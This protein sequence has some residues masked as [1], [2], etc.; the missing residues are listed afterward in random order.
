MHDRGRASNDSER[1]R[2]EWKI[3]RS[4]G[5]IARRKG[6]RQEEC[7]EGD[8]PSDGEEATANASPEPDQT[9]PSCAVEGDPLTRERRAEEHAGEGEQPASG[10]RTARSSLHPRHERAAGA[11]KE[12]EKV[13]VVHADPALYEGGAV[14]KREGTDERGDVAPL[15]EESGEERQECRRQRAGEDARPTP[16]CGEIADRDLHHR[17]VS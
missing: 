12:D 16:P 14:E 2:S 4:H 15:G 9:E 11:K 7:E 17:A 1:N 3:W 8:E 6:L 13:D 5:P 10:E